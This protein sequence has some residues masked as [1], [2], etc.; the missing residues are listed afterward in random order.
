M[1]LAPELGATRVAERYVLLD[2]LG[3]GGMG[4]VYRAR[5]EASGR[6][7]AFKQLIPGKTSSKR[8]MFEA[9]FEREYHT[10]VRLKHPR[11]IEVHEYG[12]SE[13]G[14]YYTMELL[15]GKDLQ[16]LAPLP[17]RE[18]CGHL[19]DVA[20]SLAL[21]HAH[22]LLHRDLSPRNLRLTADGRVKLIDFGGLCAFGPADDVVG[23]AMC[24][25]PEIMRRTPLDQRA[26]LYGLGAVGYWL[27]TGR[28]AYPARHI[29]DLPS[30]W[31]RP[32]PLPS[33]LVAGIPP[34]LDQL[35]MSLLSIEPLARPASAAAVIDRLTAVGELSPEE[36]E[37]AAISYLASGKLVGRQT[38]QAW[39]RRRFSRAVEGRGA[40][41]VIDGAAGVGKTRLLHEASLEAQLKGM[42]ALRVDAQACPE[43]FGVARALALQLMSTCPEIGRRTLEPYS[44]LLGHLSPALAGRVQPL[45]LAELQGASERRL[46]LRT[47]LYEWFLDVAAA[48]PL[49][50]AVDNLH[51]ADDNSA[52]FLA[53]LGRKARR[54]SLVL[55]ATQRS[56]E[57]VAAPGP[58]RALRKHGSRLKL[59][60]LD[61]QAC[62]E[63]VKSLFGDVAN[64][65]RVARLLYDKSAGNPQLCMDLAQLL[66]KR[67]IVRYAVGAWVLP[68]QISARELPSHVD[69][70]L[71]VKLAGLSASAR[72]LAEILSIQGKPVSLEWCLSLAERKDE[73]EAHA[74]LDEL[75]T[76]Q[77]LVV[78]NGAYHFGQGALRE[79]LLSKMEPA[80]RS[81]RHL[82]AGEMLLAS[83]APDHLETRMEAA[84]HLLRGGAELRGADLL[85]NSSRA[86]LQKQGA[87]ESAEQI[88]QG[89]HAAVAVYERHGRS[90]Y[91]I[92]RLLFPMIPFGFYCADWRLILDYAGRALELGLEIT[93]LSFAYS[94][95]PLLGKEMALQAGLTSAALNFKR[96]QLAGLDYS[97]EEALQSCCAL[98][99]AAVG[100]FSICLDHVSVKRLRDM[101]KPLTL[102]PDDQLP[103]LVYEFVEALAL[104]AQGRE[105]ESLQCRRSTLERFR[106]PKLRELLGES[107][108]RSLY[109][110][111]MFTAAVMSCHCGDPRALELA[112]EL[113]ELGIRMW[114]MNAAQVRMLYHAYAG[115]SEQVQRQRERI[116]L[117][118]VQGSTTWQAEIFLP[119]VLVNADILSGDAIATRR[120]W[121]QLARRSREVPTL[122]LQAQAAHAAYMALRGDLA[123]AIALYETILPALPPREASG[124]LN[125]RAFFAQ[126]LNR[127]GQH[128]RAKQVL[129]EAFAA[130]TDNDEAVI[131]Y[132]LIARCQLA[133]AEAGL[134]N[135]ELAAQSLDALLTK[136]ESL[137][138]PML[139][140]LMH[141]ARAEVA[142]GMLDRHGF[143][144]HLAAM[145]LRFRR[146]RNPALMAHHARLCERAARAGLRHAASV[147]PRSDCA[148]HGQ[149]GEPGSSPERTIGEISVATD[150]CEFALQFILKSTRARAGYLYML[151]P[152][153]FRLAAATP[154]AELPKGLETELRAQANQ[155]RSEPPHATSPALSEAPQEPAVA[156]V[157]T[158]VSGERSRMRAGM[159][160]ARSRPQ[161]PQQQAAPA[162]SSDSAALSPPA[163][164]RPSE[165]RFAIHLLT[166][167]HGQERLVVGG[168][169]LEAEAQAT[170]Q[171]DSQV[172]QS[173]AKALH[174]RHVTT[175]VH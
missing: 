29:D 133:L 130:A 111:M 167:S 137:E 124:W 152:D 135:H 155:L 26:D 88:V 99:P 32:P 141:E 24:M 83:A 64:A 65:G 172:L 71:A 119:S 125:T 77:V 149:A 78:E 80:E 165:P 50:V 89:L 109:G 169:I 23:T 63:L 128:A 140:G 101:L 69:E 104:V 2:K 25:P 12:F 102:F 114:A 148:P 163:S 44:A 15:D 139:V 143:D 175:S 159:R 100:T 162:S 30:L 38:E 61:A 131:V 20:S 67:R 127:A 144:M 120:S 14:P 54:T 170:L 57:A 121:E 81:A 171:L 173:I 132:S 68:Q 45:Q 41:V 33:A 42:I 116:E 43:P 98:V 17:Y 117:F 96:E 27:L 106:N 35:I 105:Y 3:E 164:E 156:S 157:Q 107:H 31:Q 6:L 161:R 48:R 28:H 123:A 21:I 19:R 134:G 94:L 58:V 166:V 145:Q 168:L 8:G 142:L 154:G 34:E 112:T 160:G 150:R 87:G 91:E 36:H 103:H 40:E 59:L 5:D 115:N 95:E 74:A 13:S 126:A 79:A 39:A 62:E 92:A 4:A 70:L 51:A 60:G 22:R 76:E 174:E 18:A 72:A 49:L 37:F 66:V 138:S 110:G 9:L 7:V 75:L 52:A 82:R 153:G 151:E 118:A 136:H 47:A 10:L 55:L 11:I 73:S 16:Q 93:G 147:E 108:W 129:E 84:W 158:V 46:R 1:R 113:E 90:R 85:A 122:R 86:F 56:G 97:L 146:T 53:A